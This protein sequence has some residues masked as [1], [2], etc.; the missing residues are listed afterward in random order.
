[1]SQENEE[2]DAIVVGAG[3][4]GLFAVFA[5]GMLRLRCHVVETLEAVGG[6]LAA[7][8]PT[9]PIYDMPGFPAITAAEVVERLAGQAEPF[10]PHYHLAS[11]AETLA[12]TPD[13]RWRMGLSSGRGLTAPVV[14]IA[15]GAGAFGPNRPPLAGIEDY[16]GK[17]V[18]YVVTRRQDFAGKRVVIAGGGDSAADW[19]IELA[20]V[21]A[22]VQVVHRRPRF[23]CAPES[24]AR[25]KALAESGRIEL[26]VPCQ[27]DALEGAEGRLAAVVVADLDGNRR[28]LEADVLLPFF[29]LAGELGAIA[30]WGLAMDQHRIAV[31]PATLAT[32]L[33]GVFAIGDVAAYP[34]KLKLILQAFSEAAMMAQAAHAVARPGTALHFEHST[35]SGVPTL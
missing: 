7:L 8:Y 2:T 16:E 34:G 10:A 27:L 1:M 4:A 29:G 14:V 33:P 18:F 26:V 28:R 31:D 23:R 5:L 35:T 15:A 17:S 32:N 21:A 12:R 22:S 20:E 11:R 25:L 6:Q 13:G 24:E 9:K 30:Q 19:A 3:P